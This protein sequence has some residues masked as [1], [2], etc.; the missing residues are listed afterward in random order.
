MTA[1][2][3]EADQTRREPRAEMET[4]PSAGKDSEELKAKSDEERTT[5]VWNKK[6]ILAGL[7]PAERVDKLTHKRGVSQQS[8]GS[9]EP[10]S[11]VDTEASRRS[12]Q[13]VKPTLKLKDVV[14]GADLD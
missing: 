10:T 9:S 3:A 4:G 13:R 5:I 1:I 2:R 12:K 8:I 6:P 7:Q 14:Q 11:M